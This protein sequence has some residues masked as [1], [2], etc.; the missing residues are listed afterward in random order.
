MSDIAKFKRNPMKLAAID[1]FAL[2]P[3]VTAKEV[4]K[5][6]NISHHTVHAWRKDPNFIDACYERYMI[7]F[8]SLLPSV[9]NSMIRE[10]QAGNVQAGRLVLEHSGKL[11][12]N[13][14][15]TV[16]SVFTVLLDIDGNLYTSLSEKFLKADVEIESDADVLDVMD[17]V[18]VE[19]IKLPDRKEENQNLRT[20]KEKKACKN[21]IKTEKK[22]LEYN[23]KQKEWYRWRKRAEKAG[24]KPLKNRRPTPAQ[25]KDWQNEIIKAESSQTN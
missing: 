1:M 5:K 23:E 14:N 8:G 4:A 22:R 13:I 20:K 9:L 12:K 25:R 7:E 6:L 18:D 19:D 16:D 15:V 21:A 2:Q 10:A 11:V 17:A 24:I 3:L